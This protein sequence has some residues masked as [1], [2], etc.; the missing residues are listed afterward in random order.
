MNIAYWLKGW[1]PEAEAWLHTEK[2]CGPGKV[3]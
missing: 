3:A 1:P 2:L